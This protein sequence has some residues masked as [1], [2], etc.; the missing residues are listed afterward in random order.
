MPIEIPVVDVR[1]LSVHCIQNFELEY[2]EKGVKRQYT[3]GNVSV[4][5]WYLPE[6]TLE[7]LNG[8]QVL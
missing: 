4:G 8:C 1:R 7:T 6:D 3:F 2:V 5:S